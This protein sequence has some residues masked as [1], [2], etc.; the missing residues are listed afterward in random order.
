M[1]NIHNA[2]VLVQFSDE[3]KRSFDLA[4]NNEVECENQDY[5]IDERIL[6]LGPKSDCIVE[7]LE[8]N[9]KRGNTMDKQK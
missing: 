1:A 9:Y 2:V 6:K 8:E 7:L 5:I 4:V 3:N